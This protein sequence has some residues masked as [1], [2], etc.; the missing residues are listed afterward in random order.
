MFICFSCTYFTVPNNLYIFFFVA[1]G[2]N[3]C[4]D[5]G[6]PL[7]GRRFGDSFQLGSSISVVCEE[8]FIK[9]QG[10]DTI[11]CHLEDG[12]AMW[13]GLIPKCEGSTSV[14]IFEQSTVQEL[15]EF[16]VQTKQSQARKHL[17]SAVCVI[18]F[19]THMFCSFFHVGRQ[20]FCVFF[21]LPLLF[22]PLNI[23][24]HSSN[25]CFSAPPAPCGG[26]Y[27]GPSGVIL[28]PGWPGY[29][30]DSL[31]CEWVIEA[32]AGRSIK[33]SFD[34]SVWHI[35]NN[36]TKKAKTQT[37]IACVSRSSYKNNNFILESFRKLNFGVL[38]V[39]S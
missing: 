12:K 6:I 32:E 38:H 26:H 13:S 34:R 33:I 5:P 29:Y 11:T 21:M 37:Q 28:S 10:A 35:W 8:G 30:K 15:W 22:S 31:S 20:N 9:T 4:P 23:F 27:S 24:H 25:W 16:T 7:N 39:T 17:F 3:E 14:I 36:S 18:S 19:V 1:F 2:H